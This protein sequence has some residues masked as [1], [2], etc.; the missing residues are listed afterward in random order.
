MYKLVLYFEVLILA[1]FYRIITGIFNPITKELTVLNRTAN[2][3]SNNN[4]HFWQQRKVVEIYNK[5]Y[6]ERLAALEKQL[7]ELNHHE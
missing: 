7:K 2:F 1:T 5:E 6:T 4:C 3:Y